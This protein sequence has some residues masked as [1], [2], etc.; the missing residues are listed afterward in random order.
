MSDHNLVP[1]LTPDVDAAVPPITLPAVADRALTELEIAERGIAELTRGDAAGAEVAIAEPARARTGV[2]QKAPRAA[3]QWKTPLFLL[4]MQS[5][6]AT[7]MLTRVGRRVRCALK[8]PEPLK[9]GSET[10]EYLGDLSE[11][12]RYAVIVG[13]IRRLCPSASVLDVGSSNGV[14]AEELRT[15]VR[16]IR[17]IEYDPISVERASER[18]IDNATFEVADANTFT[19]TE[20]FDVVVFNETLYYLHDPIETLQRYAGFLK[21]EGVLIVS[22]FVARY[23]LKFPGEIARNFEV[24]EQANVINSRGFG[25]TIQA[26]RP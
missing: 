18:K 2:H 7:E 17:G 20:R 22:N 16:R 24:I 25:W 11:V 26:L 1:T 6:L 15:S 23:L 13:Y 10:W 9:G 19:T 5:R 21:P 4:A 14:L 8:E 3:R 12:A